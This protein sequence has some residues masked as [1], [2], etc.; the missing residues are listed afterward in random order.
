MLYLCASA[1]PYKPATLG[2]PAS[3][4]GFCGGAEWLTA[5]NSG[6]GGRKSQRL[7]RRRPE[8]EPVVHRPGFPPLYTVRACNFIDFRES[9]APSRA[10][11]YE[12]GGAPLVH[13]RQKLRE[14]KKT[15]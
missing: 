6:S 5:Q 4:R 1:Q 13:T 2:L 9:V 8:A 14:S 7:A 3:A 15:P 11:E 10:A 12:H